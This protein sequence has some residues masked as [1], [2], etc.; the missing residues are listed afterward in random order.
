MADS[1]LTSL[2][3]PDTGALLTDGAEASIPSRDAHRQFVTR[4]F[5][6]YRGYLLAYLTSLLGTRED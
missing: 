1:G 3:L 2:A 6:E 5:E 4:L